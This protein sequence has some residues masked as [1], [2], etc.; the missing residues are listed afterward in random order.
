MEAWWNEVVYTIGLVIEAMA[1]LVIGYASIE[2]FIRVLRVG[3][4][5]TSEAEKRR[6]YLRYLRWLVAGLTFQLASDIVHTAVVPSWEQLVR[7]AVIAIIRTFLGFFLDRD[8]R[9]AASGDLAGVS[10]DKKES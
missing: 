3:L 9:A 8:M 7:V 5:R 2:A 4:T 1:V 10:E 6:V